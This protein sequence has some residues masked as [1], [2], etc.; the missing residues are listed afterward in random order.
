METCHAVHRTLGI[1]MYPVKENK[2]VQEFQKWL[3]WVGDRTRT[4]PS[5]IRGNIGRENY[6]TIPGLAY[7]QA[8]HSRNLKI[9]SREMDHQ[10]LSCTFDSAVQEL[11][12][13]EPGMRKQ[14]N[15]AIANSCQR[16]FFVV[17]EIA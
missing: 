4:E 15:L 14:T 13:K 1:L 6:K 12:N 17:L 16:E 5:N 10:R 7:P 2:I 8:E 11:K 9:Y 3:T